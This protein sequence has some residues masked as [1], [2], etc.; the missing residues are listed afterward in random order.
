MFSRS[1][2]FKYSH[3]LCDHSRYA[4]KGGAIFKPTT[5]VHE[6]RV[7]TRWIVYSMVAFTKYN[8]IEF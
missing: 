1:S 8:R 7:L 5:S 2:I 4:V 6:I 3:I